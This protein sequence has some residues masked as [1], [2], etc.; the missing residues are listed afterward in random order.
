MLIEQAKL[1]EE[2][3]T[4]NGARAPWNSFFENSKMAFVSFKK[5][6]EQKILMLTTMGPA[7][8]QNLNLKL[9]VFWAHQK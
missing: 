1:C 5:K 7:S 6:L 9:V 4:S 3:E 2:T 8:V